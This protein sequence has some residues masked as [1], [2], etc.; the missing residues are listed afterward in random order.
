M[1]KRHIIPASAAFHRCMAAVLF[2]TLTL[3]NPSLYAQT[4]ATT[5]ATKP[6]QRV[7]AL[8]KIY[9]VLKDYYDTM[10]AMPANLMDLYR[11]AF[12]DDPMVFFLKNSP[13][14]TLAKQFPE[15]ATPSFDILAKQ[16]Q[17]DICACGPFGEGEIFILSADGAVRKDKVDLLEYY[18]KWNHAPMPPFAKFPEKELKKVTARMGVLLREIKTDKA[19]P[20]VVVD[21]IIPGYRST[22]K[23]VYGDRVFLAPGD[24]L[25]RVAGHRVKDLASLEKAMAYLKVRSGFT[26]VVLRSKLLMAR[27]LRPVMSLDRSG[28]RK[29]DPEWISKA[30]SV[31]MDPKGPGLIGV[32]TKDH[33]NGQ[34]ITSMNKGS[35]GEKSGLQKGDIITSVQGTPLTSSAHL[36][37]LVKTFAAGTTVKVGLLRAGNQKTLDVRLGS[38]NMTSLNQA[39]FEILA[40]RLR[41]NEAMKYADSIIAVNMVVEL[42]ESSR[43]QKAALEWIS[44][45]ITQPSRIQRSILWQLYRVRAQL[46]ERMGRWKD[47]LT[48]LKQVSKVHGKTPPLYKEMGNI[49]WRRK[50]YDNAISL[51]RKG[52]QNA[53]KWS[54]PGEMYSLG[55]KLLMINRK[56]DARQIFEELSTHKVYGKMAKKKLQKLA[57]DD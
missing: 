6:D 24:R 21:R 30:A 12:V 53:S 15:R 9:P 14:Y 57:S 48:D 42:L 54:R 16:W 1:K 49:H 11:E 41:V 39:R 28:R 34:E 2:F 52:I 3:T 5:P 50:D 23:P 40:G 10:E 37:D 45:A 46:L 43:G 55:T 8:K 29:D 44:R 18:G 4:A 19:T 27:P 32:F 26:I 56:K 22:Y 25:I 51:Y 36:S 7:T 35:A 38:L 33:A 13:E 47:A 20:A 31:Y 17:G